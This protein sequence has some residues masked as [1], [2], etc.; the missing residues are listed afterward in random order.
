M[1]LERKRLYA[2][3]NT[4]MD[5][6]ESQRD[7]LTGLLNRLGLAAALQEFDTLGRRGLTLFSVQLARFGHINSS[8]GGEIAD[9][10]IT[11]TARRLQKTFPNALHIARTHGDHFC[12]LFEGLDAV[13]E[14]IERLD[15]FTRRPFAVQGEI[16]VLSVRCGVARMDD[17]LGSAGMLLHGSETALQVAKATKTRAS[18]YK[19]EMEEQARQAHRFENDLRV[20]IV[21][22][23]ADLHR[24]LAN[25]EFQVHYQPIIECD[26]GQL[27]AFEALMRWSH[28]TNG[29][30]R[31]DL[32]I[33][34]AE[35]IQVMHI[36]GS[37]VIQ[38]AIADA[39]TWPPRA[40]GQAVGVSIN[41][42][43]CQF[44][45]PAILLNTVSQALDQTKLDP[46]LVKLEI[47]ESSA[48]VDTMSE[49]LQRLKDMGC[50]IA[51]DDFGKGYSCLTQ[52]HELPL[53]YMKL[54]RSFLNDLES[55][56]P[57]K[58]MR[59]RKLIQAILALSGTFD[60]AAIAEGVE[61]RQQLDEVRQMGAKLVQGFL[62]SRARPASEIPD[63]IKNFVPGS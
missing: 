6:S 12:L 56:D 47:T 34:L 49:T 24:A 29:P 59:S 62:Y 13:E 28:P 61:T 40:D 38:K 36:L 35:Q 58:A 46:A 4:S 33:P 5:I 54:D 8:L 10:I 51:L 50:R 3:L 37:W 15:D 53:D 45:E 32:F 30:V 48:F 9:R 60:I 17:S 26:T 1:L 57:D 44:I 20:S 41:I 25:D 11:L 31:P 22:H 39:A 19:P 23:H 52:L 18:F 21:N 43:A 55:K 63:Y 42:S 2:G 16:I 27:Y 7:P 14:T